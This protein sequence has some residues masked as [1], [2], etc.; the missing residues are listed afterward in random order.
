MQSRTVSR[1]TL[2]FD[3]LLSLSCADFW[4]SQLTRI[5]SHDGVLAATNLVLCRRERRR[6]AFHATRGVDSITIRRAAH[7]R[8]HWLYGIVG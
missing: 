7:R 1:L 8:H 4:V 6:A 3:K 5:I 2:H